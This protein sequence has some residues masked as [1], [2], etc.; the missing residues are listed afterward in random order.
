MNKEITEGELLSSTLVARLRLQQAHFPIYGQKGFRQFLQHLQ[1]LR[2]Q[3]E[4]QTLLD[5][6]SLT[7]VMLYHHK[8]FQK[9]LCPLEDVGICAE[10]GRIPAAV[11]SQ[12]RLV[13]AAKCYQQLPEVACGN[14]QKTG[15]ED[16]LTVIHVVLQEVALTTEDKCLPEGDKASVTPDEVQHHTSDWS[17]SRAEEVNWKRHETSA[18]SSLLALHDALLVVCKVLTGKKQQ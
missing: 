1:F 13:N 2:N 18:G 11:R 7:A 16:T 8:G 5:V 17:F 9:L 12:V 6:C 14:L 4:H 10:P 15:G 3:T